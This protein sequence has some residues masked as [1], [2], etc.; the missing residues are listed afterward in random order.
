MVAEELFDLGSNCCEVSSAVI[1]FSK[2]ELWARKVSRIQFLGQ[3]ELF[4]CLLQSVPV[5]E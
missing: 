4:L 1:D 3:L 5:G 2:R